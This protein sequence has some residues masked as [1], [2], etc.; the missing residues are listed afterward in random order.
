LGDK[1]ERLHKGEK[2][3]QQTLGKIGRW[4][5]EIHITGLGP[6]PEMGEDTKSGTSSRAQRSANGVSRLIGKEG[7]KIKRQ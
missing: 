6:D 1:N 7:E 5:Q 4:G 2:Q 3:K